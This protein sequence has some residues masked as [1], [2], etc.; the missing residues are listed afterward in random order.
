MPSE[1]VAKVV[2]HRYRALVEGGAPPSEWSYAWRAELNRGGFRTVDFLMDEVVSQGKCV[3][4]ASCVTIC[5]ADVFEYQDER[6]VDLRPDACVQCILCADVCPILRAPELG[7]M[8]FRSPALEDGFGPYSYEVLSRATAPEIRDRA[9]DGGTASAL[10]LRA[11]ETEVIRGVVLGDVK[12][13]DPQVGEQRLATTAEEVLRCRGSRYTYSP[14]TLALQE[15]VARDVHP[16]AVVGV[17]CQVEGLRHQQ[18]SGVPL[19]INRW[20]QRNVTLVIGLFCSESFTHESIS[21]IAERFDVKR[22]DVENINIKGKIVVRLSDGRT[23]NL[24]LKEFRTYAR[25]ACDFCTDYAAE[26]SDIALGGIGLDGWT[27]T[28][29][30]TDAGHDAFQAAIDAGEIEVRDVSDAPRSRP[31][32]QKLAAAKHSRALPAQ[33]AGRVPP[34]SAGAELAPEGAGGSAQ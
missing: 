12:E 30:R 14:N 15:A 17:P 28:V 22:T 4:C 2:Q 1:T 25:P 21:A 23:E 20:L 32:L 19:Q 16:I 27:Y 9:Q 34:E 6:P 3:G 29:V 13:S 24:S 5:S 18:A 33:Q 7:T 10:L 8:S 31:L 11:L 26:R